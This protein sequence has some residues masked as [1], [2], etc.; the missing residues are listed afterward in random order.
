MDKIKIIITTGE[1]HDKE[2]KKWIKNQGMIKIKS[3]TTSGHQ[4]H[5]GSDI[6]VTNIVYEI[7]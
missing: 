2:V 4:D 3:S 5:F 7:V 1:Y 6:F